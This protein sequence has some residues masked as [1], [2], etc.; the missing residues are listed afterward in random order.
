MDQRYSPSQDPLF[1][2]FENS[3]NGMIQILGK[4]TTY[5]GLSPWD[6]GYPLAEKEYI[7][8]EITLRKLQF[9]NIILIGNP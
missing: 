2:I 5:V 8:P 9:N 1:A 6:F 3:S 4:S 7:Q